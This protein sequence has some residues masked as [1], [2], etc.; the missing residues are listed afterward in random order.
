[1]LVLF[2][3]YITAAS[4]RYT[5]A[6]LAQP[7][8]LGRKPEYCMNQLK[9]WSITSDPETFRQGTTAFR[10]AND[11]EK[12]QRDEAITRANERANDSQAGALAVDESFGLVSSFVSEASLD[13]LCTIEAISQESRTSPNEGS[14]ITANLQESE[15]S[16]DELL[17]DFR[18]PAKRFS[19]HSKRPR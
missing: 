12:E 15:T 18:L 17:S 5:P 19:R 6:T 7:T 14:N 13:E 8:S 10:N 16:T 3:Q 1:M 2:R 9:G 4:S 11:W